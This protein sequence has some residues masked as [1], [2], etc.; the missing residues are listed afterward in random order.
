[1]VSEAYCHKPKG[2]GDCQNVWSRL[3]SLSCKKISRITSPSDFSRDPENLFLNCDSQTILIFFPNLINKG[4]RAGF[5]LQPAVCNLCHRI[6]RVKV[7]RQ[8]A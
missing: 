5:G 7:S 1:M 8:L 6:F 4:F 3:S 2:N